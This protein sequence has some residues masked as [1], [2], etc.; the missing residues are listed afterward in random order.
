MQIAS[1]NILN[2]S[3]KFLRKKK[4]FFFQNVLNL[5]YFFLCYTNIFK[6][7]QIRN[8]TRYTNLGY[9]NLEFDKHMIF[10]IFVK[11]IVGSHI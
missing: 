4:V 11:A 10:I 5:I 9:F 8:K 2:N 6:V 3:K 1:K 7:P